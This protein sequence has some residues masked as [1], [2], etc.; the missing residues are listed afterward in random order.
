MNS[1]VNIVAFGIA[2]AVMM[3]ALIGLLL[4]A[5]G[6]NAGRPVRI[7]F[8]AVAVVLLLMVPS[9]AALNLLAAD[10]SA[11]FGRALLVAFCVVAIVY[12]TNV[13]LIPLALRRAAAA[14]GLDRPAPLRL[15]PATLLG[16]LI[17]CAALGALDA[18][19]A[20]AA[21]AA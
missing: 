11:G 20:L 1:L 14:R 19:L 13:A 17:I 3:A 9:I 5:S 16:G 18:G 6:R 4:I 12:A 2:G 10:P 15:T 8:G 7:L 21:N